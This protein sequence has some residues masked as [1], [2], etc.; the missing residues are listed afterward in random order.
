[1]TKLYWQTFFEIISTNHRSNFDG[2]GL[3][4]AAGQHDEYCDNHDDSTHVCCNKLFHK[5][6]PC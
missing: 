4:F 2:Y 1:M 6:T 3:R 5:A